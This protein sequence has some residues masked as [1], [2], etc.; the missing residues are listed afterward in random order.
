MAKIA[1]AISARPPQKSRGLRIK[2]PRPDR[3]WD[4]LSPSDM[5]PPSR[6]AHA[7]R[8]SQFGL[9]GRSVAHS[10]G[11][12]EATAAKLS[13]DQSDKP[14]Q[15]GCGKNPQGIQPCRVGHD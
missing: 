2:K 6:P 12:R 11:R 10:G 15:R 8:T 7:P 14:K 4:E 9:H 5:F 13:S 1:K 3:F